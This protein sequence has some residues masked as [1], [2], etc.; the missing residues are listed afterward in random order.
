MAPSNDILLA[1][2]LSDTD[3]RQFMHSGDIRIDPFDE[4]SLKGASYTLALGSKLRIPR[5]TSVVRA[6]SPEVTYEEVE[7]DE[8]GY[9]VEPG[10]FM[11]G[12][13]HEQLS[14]S[15]RLSCALDA[16][17]TLARIGLNVLQGS[18]LIEPGQ[19]DSHETLEIHNIGPSPVLIVP[20]L[21]VVKAVFHLLR[22]PAGQAY[23]GKYVAQ[24]DPSV[25]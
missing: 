21:K 2:V 3:I 17:T 11:L 18:T 13:V 22:T 15:T 6:D 8:S 10:A 4:G 1:M 20:G 12:Q 16:R 9:V 7:M 24:T 19:H 14:I 5:I 23:D 25:R